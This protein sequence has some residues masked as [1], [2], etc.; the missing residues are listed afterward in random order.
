MKP[1]DLHVDRSHRLGHPRPEWIQPAV[2]VLRLPRGWVG[3]DVGEPL[4][5]RA[6]GE[7]EG[8]EGRAGVGMDALAEAQARK[9]GGAATSPGRRPVKNSSA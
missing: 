7:D 5:I 9:V 8:T 3:D 1:A 2:E 6:R 4:Q